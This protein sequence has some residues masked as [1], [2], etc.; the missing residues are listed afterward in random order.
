MCNCNKPK[1]EPEYVVK[2][3]DGREKT[4]IGENAARIE[5]TLAG[6]GRYEAKR[7]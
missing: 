6:G 7:K 1:Q 5:V 4:V 2:L 3:P